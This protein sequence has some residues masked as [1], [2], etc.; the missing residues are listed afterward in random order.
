[1]EY[2]QMASYTYGI[3]SSKGGDIQSKIRK[4][5]EKQT[6]G[7]SSKDKQKK[8]TSKEAQALRRSVQEM[9]RPPVWSDAYKSKAYFT[10]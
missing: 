4:Y 3:N 10:P 5:F 6:K 2:Y 9:L 8:A 1:M 7:L